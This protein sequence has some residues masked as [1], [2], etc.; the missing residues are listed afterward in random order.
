MN[1]YERVIKVKVSIINGCGNNTALE[2]DSI[3]E[4]CKQ[5]KEKNMNYVINNLDELQLKYCIGCDSCQNINPGICAINDG[6]NDMLKQYLNSDI[7]IIV[8]PIQ[9]G[10][11]NSI[12]KNFIDRTE[13]LFLPYQSS[14]NGNTV[15]KPRYKNYP[16]IIF[17]GIMEARDS[18]SEQNFKETVTSCNLS[19]ASNKVITKII[20]EKADLYNF[21]ELD[22]YKGKEA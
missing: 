2:S 22:L 6:I 8:T 5:L 11:C 1:K 9:F 10:C 17:I 7:S 14:K 4:I 18:D 15:M 20:T 13:P 16:N 19:E 21:K 12:T 3:N